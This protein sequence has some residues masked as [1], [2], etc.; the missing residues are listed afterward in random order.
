MTQDTQNTRV[1]VNPTLYKMLGML[2]GMITARAVHVAAK[3]RIADLLK[4]DTKSITELAESS[5]TNPVALHRLLSALASTGVFEEVETGHFKNTPLSYYLRSDTS[6]SLLDAAL[7]WGSDWQWEQWGALDYTIETGQ[8]AFDHLFHMPIWDYLEQHP[9]DERIFSSG[10]TS[11]SRSLVPLIVQSYDFSGLHTVVDVG[12]GEGDL[13][14]ELLQ[15]Y[16]SLQGVLFERPTMLSVAH[17]HIAN[18]HLLN[19]CDLMAGD[20]FQRVPQGMDAYIVRE[21][22]HDWDEQ[23]CIDILQSCHKAMRPDSRLLVVEHI[24]HPD[25]KRSF[26]KFLG[27]QMML[28]QEGHERTEDELRKIHEAAGFR[29]QRIIPIPEPTTTIIESIPV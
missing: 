3:F 22:L 6:D 10:L 26:T 19:R 11:F 29:I 1:G 15:H 18:A 2:R 8:R 20:F 16:P 24:A 14:V 9:E 12:G 21:V 25:D 13:L 4:D 5:H 27:L 17:D 7:Y 28:E 23:H